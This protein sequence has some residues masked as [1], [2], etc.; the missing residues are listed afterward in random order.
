MLQ[1]ALMP[2]LAQQRVVRTP[3]L[4]PQ[5]EI[6]IITMGPFQGELYS[7]FGH[8]GIRVNDPGISVDAFYNYGAFSF[9]QPNFYLNFARGYL[10]YKL[11]VD[12]YIPWRDYYISNNR[13]VHEQVLN[14]NDEETQKVFDYLY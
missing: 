12:P 11:D 5:A 1:A 14:L 4:S 9:N 10:N 7:A 6:S 2:L 13:F 3:Q 8:S